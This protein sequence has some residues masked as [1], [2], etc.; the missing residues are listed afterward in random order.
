MFLGSF[1]ATMDAKGRFILPADLRAKITEPGS[2]LIVTAD[3]MQDCLLIYTPTEWN[4]VTDA[5][6]YQPDGDESVR[7]FKQ[8][9]IGHAHELEM[10]GS[11]RLNVPIRLRKKVGL[12]KALVTR[13]MGKKVELWSEER[14]IEADA[15]REAKLRK[16]KA[17]ISISALQY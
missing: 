14:L 6:D 2:G 12:E 8:G 7:F 13:G 16:K 9:L 17:R 11:G 3:P 15:E 10:D 1:E 5:L 4:K